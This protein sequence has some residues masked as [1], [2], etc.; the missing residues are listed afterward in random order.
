MV[1]NEEEFVG[2]RLEVLKRGFG[3]GGGVGSG[4]EGTMQD[5]SQELRSAR[6]SKG[7]SATVSIGK[8]AS[9]GY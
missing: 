5:G 8:G 1:R 7:L 2:G 6:D 4:M 9:E 3:E